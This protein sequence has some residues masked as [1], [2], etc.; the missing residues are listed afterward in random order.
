MICS[1][2]GVEYGVSFAL[3]LV[4]GTKWVVYYVNSADETGKQL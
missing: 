4:S 3:R 1:L 2:L